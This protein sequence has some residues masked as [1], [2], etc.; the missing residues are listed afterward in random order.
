MNALYGIDISSHRRTALAT[1]DLENFDYVVPLDSQICDYLREK[2][3]L[4]P[5]KI[6]FT[7]NINDP[8]GSGIDV[9]ESCAININ[10]MVGAVIEELLQQGNR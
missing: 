4:D 2:T 6:I 9:Y 1:D 7:H 3:S 8:Y 10:E 5:S